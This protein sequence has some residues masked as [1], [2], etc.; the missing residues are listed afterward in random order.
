MKLEL[1]PGRIL[2]TCFIALA[3]MAVSAQINFTN[4]EGVPMNFL[5]KNKTYEDVK[6]N[7]SPYLNDE[8]RYGR[9]YAYDSL[10]LKG[11]MRYN[12][13]KSEIEVAEDDDSYFSLLKR[14]YISVEIA[15]E[16]FEMMPYTDENELSRVAYFNPKNKGEAVLLFK[17]EIK[18]RKGR[19]PNTSYDRYVPPTY[20]D[21]SSYYLKMGDEP[22]RKIRLKKK[23]LVQA[24]KSKKDSVLVYIKESDLKLSKEQDVI[25]LLNYYNTL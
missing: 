19:V 12:A 25:K 3:P 22:A 9:V 7:G 17:P 8:F 13:Y 16:R 15:D 24:L 20:I 6:A 2:K 23:D 1:V 21:I 4:P 10:K 5:T 14:P 11:E 18:L